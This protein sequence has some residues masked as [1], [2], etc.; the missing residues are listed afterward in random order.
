MRGLLFAILI[1]ML[2]GCVAP[3]ERINVTVTQTV[4][5]TSEKSE[6]PDPAINFP[7]GFLLNSSELP[8]EYIM[9]PSSDPA[10]DEYDMSQNPGQINPVQHS[11]SWQPPAREAWAAIVKIR[12]TSSGYVVMEAHAWKNSDEATSA[13]WIRRPSGYC[14][15][16]ENDF[17]DHLYRQGRAFV[18]V[19]SKDQYDQYARRLAERLAEKNPNLMDYCA[20]PPTTSPTA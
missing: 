20:T 1:A 19:A 13:V 17:V 14:H 18:L 12:G 6:L 10:L 2:A 15:Y 4:V 9:A 16:E 7:W 5:P 3:S 8:Y 11:H